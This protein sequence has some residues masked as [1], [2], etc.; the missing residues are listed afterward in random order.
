MYLFLLS[1]IFYTDLYVA[2][3]NHTPTSCI[4]PCSESRVTQFIK[5]YV[6]SCLRVSDSNTELSYILPSESVRKGCFE[7][8]FQVFCFLHSY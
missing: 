1:L 2:D 7:R 4:S 8:L 5:K 3:I 6:A